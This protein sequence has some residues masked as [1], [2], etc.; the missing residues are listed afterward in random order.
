MARTKASS[1]L[2][3]LV[4]SDSEDDLGGGTAAAAAA[5][6]KTAKASTTTATKKTTSIR[7]MPPKKGRQQAPAA[8]TKASSTASKIT[9][10]AQKKESAAAIRRRAAAAEAAI[11]E[12]A[13]EA[14]ATSRQVLADRT[15]EQLAEA[16]APAKAKGRGRTGRKAAAAAAA[17][18]TE[19]GEDTD[20]ETAASAKAEETAKNRGRGRPK[21]G[22]QAAKDKD[23]NKGKEAPKASRRKAAAAGKKAAV[24]EEDE[25]ME[26]D[27]TAEA[28]EGDDQDE[29]TQLTDSM[30]IDEKADDETTMHA[31]TEAPPATSQAGFQSPMRR[32][33]PA[34]RPSSALRGKGVAVSSEPSGDAAVRRRLGDLTKK[35]DSLEVRFQN[36]RDVGVKEA[37]RNFER[38]KRQG[39]ERVKISDELI[40][41]LRAELA[42]Y[43]D[44]AKEG[45]RAKREW[46]ACEARAA[47]LQGRVDQ[48]TAALGDAKAEARSLTTKLAAA[49]T[50]VAEGVAAGAVAGVVPG[51]AMKKMAGH[52]GLAADR[53]A[54]AAAAAASQVVQLKENLYGDL[55]GLLVYSARRDGSRELY[56][57]IQTGR[58]G[59]LHFKLCIDNDSSHGRD[60]GGDDDNE[61]QFVYMPQL[62]ASR[63]ADLISRLPDYLVEEIS[64]PRAQA[65]KFYSRV[66]QSL[67][68]DK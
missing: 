22:A 54:A 25:S 37:E 47:E 59:S 34:Q 13:E 43:R 7:D 55:T 12:A 30:D 42:T 66:V 17:V 28:E 33:Q 32:S 53:A 68:A 16:V 64:F 67:M 24:E 62:D 36:L 5:K 46:D 60:G 19:D 4:E 58:S 3:N 50:S 39:D 65:A 10:P 63:D 44:L 20:A 29:A 40:A 48:L 14:A 57:C 11:A 18:S 1:N 38:L 35:H 23:E 61:S 56:D 26:Q 27:E 8:A 9:K 15:N 31:Q 49:R 2:L 21:A 6:A 45:A 52:G 41:S 51:S